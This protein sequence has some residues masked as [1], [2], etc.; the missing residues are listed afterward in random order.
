MKIGSILVS[1]GGV[2][3]SEIDLGGS[4]FVLQISICVMHVFF[5]STAFYRGRFRGKRGGPRLGG[6]GMA[7]R[8]GGGG[9]RAHGKRGRGEEGGGEKREGKREERRGKG[10]TGR[11]REKEG[12]REL[13]IAPK[14][15]KK[16]T[17]KKNKQVQQVASIR[18]LGKFLTLKKT[19]NFWA[20]ST[21][22]D[23]CPSETPGPT[24]MPVWGSSA[25]RPESPLTEKQPASS[26]GSGPPNEVPTLYH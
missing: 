2:Y 3:S 7:G 16:T 15:R 5:S 21:D 17:T 12:E 19:K 24:G 23:R 6:R 14:N 1:R 10:E 4:H 26:N 13:F 18:I 25:T 22:S 9:K 11:E 8:R 20:D